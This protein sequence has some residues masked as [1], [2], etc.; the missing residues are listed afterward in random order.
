MKTNIHFTD[1]SLIEATNPITINLIGAGGTGSRVLTALSQTNYAL[2][3][4]N[5]AGFDVRLWDD[6]I[7][8]EANKGRQLFADSEVGFHKSVALINRTN[9]FF[10]TNWKAE[11]MLFNKKRLDH[12]AD[13]VKATI[14]ISCADNVATRFEIAEMLDTLLLGSRNHH[15]HTPKYWL[16]F[17]NSQHTGQVI[18]ATVGELQQPHSEKYNTIGKLPFVTEEY[19]ELLQQSEETDNTPSCSLADALTKQDLFINAT[20]AQMGCSLLWNMLRNGLIE[21]KGFFLN[22]KDFRS[23]PI[24]L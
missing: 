20:L 11:T 2:N 21:T 9:R 13:K 23:Q 16:D 22:L 18:L 6:D 15:H 17:G 1:S 14:T 4:L 3:E 24:T 12:D 5:H 8:T 19:G 10:G 7:V